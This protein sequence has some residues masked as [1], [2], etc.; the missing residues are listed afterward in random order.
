M[1]L[2]HTVA[3]KF[4]PDLTDA[5]IERHFKEEV[6]LQERMPDLVRW[7]SWGKNVSLQDMADVNQGCQWV[8]T[9]V[10]DDEAALATYMSHPQHLEV[11]QL[12][13]PMVVGMFVVDTISNGVP[14]KKPSWGQ[15]MGSF[16][17]PRRWL[18]G[19]CEAGANCA[20]Q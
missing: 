1:P 3:L 18:F 17:N 12:L 14:G 11:V 6:K 9:V 5:D 16:C 4:R 13:M 15:R 19:E 7:W 10:L 8:V 20:Q 2:L